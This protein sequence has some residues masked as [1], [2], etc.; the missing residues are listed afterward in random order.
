MPVNWYSN[1]LRPITHKRIKLELVMVKRLVLLSLVLVCAA[2]PGSNASE[3]P[4]TPAAQPKTSDDCP[5]VAFALDAKRWAE[6]KLIVEP[7]YPASA[8]AAGITGTVDIDAHVPSSGKISRINHITSEPKSA[9][10]EKAVM[11]VLKYWTFHGETACDCTPI[12]ADL[13]LRVWFEIRDGKP[14]ISVSAP[15]RQGGVDSSGPELLNRDALISTLTRSYPRDARRASAEGSV[16]A[17]IHVDPVTG[18]VREVEIKLFRG[19]M[20]RLFS[21]AAQEA[22]ATAEFSVD[23]VAKDSKPLVC[24]TVNYRLSGRLS[25]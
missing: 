25:D 6:P 8:L 21:E 10:L 18:S 3:K 2:V 20:K 24:L 17:A 19:S 16:H 7:E 15:P 9:A 5:G 14:V 13:K 11:D 1:R 4:A 23:G 12:A 22:L